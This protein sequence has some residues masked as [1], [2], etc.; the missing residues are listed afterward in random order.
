MSQKSLI[1]IVLSDILG[2]CHSFIIVA[3]IQYSESNF[4]EKE[5]IGL[6]IPGCRSQQEV[7]LPVTVSVK[8]KENIYI[9]ACY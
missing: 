7:R 5:F 1:L 4:E 3:V 8:S 9:F 6:S 2:L